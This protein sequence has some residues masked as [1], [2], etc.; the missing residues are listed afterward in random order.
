[1]PAGASWFGRSRSP[2]RR[3]DLKEAAARDGE[4][5]SDALGGR[6]DAL[7]AQVAL[8][9]RYF[10]EGFWKALDVAYEAISPHR[11]LC[12]V[13]CGHAAGRDGFE[14]REDRCY[15]GGGKLERYA[16]PAC[17]CVFGPQKYLDLDEAFVVRDYQVLYSRYAEGD[18]TENE[19]RAFRA[20]EPDKGGRYLDWGAG[21]GWNRTL[22]VLTGE[23]WNLVAHEPHA[24]TSD[25]GAPR[26]MA[27]PVASMGCFRTMSSSISA[28]PWRS[29]G[30]SMNCC[31]RAAKWLTLRPA[32]ITVSPSL[33]SIRFSCWAGRHLFWRNEP[34][35]RLLIAR[36]MVNTSITFS[37]V[38]EF[39]VR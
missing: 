4:A 25:L 18:S 37:S 22:A 8:T 16:C 33:A 6:L 11:P 38:F 14:I 2:S 7:E 26:G 29:F 21:G 35:L 3:D 15:F 36:G 5:R 24:A 13:V 10:I 9:E 30:N 32:T 31:A 19:L 23:G 12:C 34:D 17:D 20:L 27:S 28:I 1:M 39:A